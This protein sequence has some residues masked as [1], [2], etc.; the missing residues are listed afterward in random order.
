MDN[1][2]LVQL[3]QLGDESA[4]NKLLEQNK[5][6]IYKVINRFYINSNSIDREDL[7]QEGNIGLIVAAKKYDFNNENKAMFTTYAFYWIN[8]KISRFLTQKNTND[9]TSLDK[10]LG[11]EGNISMLNSLS[12]D[13]NTADDIVERLYQLQLKED[14]NQSMFQI[15]SLR[16]R[17]VISLMF[18]LNSTTP[19]S[20]SETGSILNITPGRVHQDKERALRKLR[21][22]A[23]KLPIQKYWNENNEEIQ[24]RKY[25]NINTLIHTTDNV[26]RC[27]DNTF[28]Y[29]K[30]IGGFKY[31]T[32]CRNKE[33]GKFTE[34][35]QGIK[36][37]S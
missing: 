29:N 6:S 2:E 37:N 7:F 15:N 14:L 13:E 22:N 31:E 8:Q 19:L 5:G 30:D 11:A 12:S 4:L 34:R 18:G 20:M 3:Y 23:S 27:I 35:L 36:S 1:E 16:E 21:I 26:V 25:N 32:N 10:P 17:E 24:E 33:Y 9:E 28:T